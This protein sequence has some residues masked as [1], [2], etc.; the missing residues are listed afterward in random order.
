MTPPM[1]F[2]SP[3][4]LINDPHDVEIFHQS[5][6]YQRVQQLILSL[7]G[8][9]HQKLC[10]ESPSD[11]TVVRTIVEIL[12]T[13]SS[14][15]DKVEPSSGP[16]RFGNIAFRQWHLMLRGST[17]I[18]DNFQWNY[19][20]DPFVELVPYFMGAFGSQ[21]RLDYGTGHELNFL[22][23]VGGLI[24]LE[25]LNDPSG[26]DLLFIFEQYFQLIRKLVVRYTLEPAGSHG[27]WGLDDHFHLPYILG[28]AQL[29]GTNS[30]LPRAVI[31]KA[32]V[33]G[34]A[35]VNLYFGAVNFIYQVKRGP[36]YEHSPT[37]YDLIG[38]PNWTK[39]HRGMIKMYMA[40]VLGKFPV[41]QHFVCGK[42]LFPW[43]NSQGDILPVHQ[44][45]ESDQDIDPIRRAFSSTGGMTR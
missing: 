20:G 35:K 2:S 40:E 37:L 7:S 19:P 43:T 22:A 11:D 4:K 13:L 1:E 12:S 38:V 31:D 36:F 5:Q 26:E 34:L 33:T 16:R 9:V 15:A 44:L 28:S 30:V 25:I 29:E 41:V 39:I 21:Q 18:Q 23:F 32:Q 6:A 24:Q 27:V 3:R 10:P 14:W 8:A 45:A 17:L 42:A